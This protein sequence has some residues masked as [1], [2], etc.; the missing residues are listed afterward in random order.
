MILPLF[1]VSLMMGC[2]KGPSSSAEVVISM[3]KTR[4]FGACPIYTVKITDDKYL[5]YSGNENVPVIGDRKVR[6]SQKEYS[7]ILKAFAEADF[8]QFES[9]YIS[10]ATD[11]PTVFLQ[12]NYGG[13]SKR[14]KDYDRAPDKLRE[15]EIKVEFL[16]KEKIWRD[17]VSR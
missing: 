10:P 13:K 6:L 9:K 2:S 8:F 16:V 11:L 4:C 7:K 14:I 1:L 5:L 12:F 15:L 17:S 3:E